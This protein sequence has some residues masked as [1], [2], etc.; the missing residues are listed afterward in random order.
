MGEIHAPTET[1]ALALFC[2]ECGSP[3]LQGE[4]FSSIQVFERNHSQ[5]EC[6]SCGWKGERRKLLASPFKH[7]FDS[8]D[9]LRDALY[10]DL[11][12]LL[13]K[14]A[15]KAYAEFLVKWGFISPP[16]TSEALT[17]YLKAIA[18]GTLSSIV[19]ERA[20]IEQEETNGS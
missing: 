3:S 8:D 20:K 19:L 13:A 11:R 16:L 17:R 7:E 6:K 5:F 15:G 10:K 18:K 4:E 2:P 9:A 1:E 14:D 12:N